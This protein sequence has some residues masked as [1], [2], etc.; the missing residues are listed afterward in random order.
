MWFGQR[1]LVIANPSAG[2]GRAAT[3]LKLLRGMLRQGDRLAL[4]EHPRHAVELAREAARSGAWPV[5][6]AAGGDG[7]AHEVACGVLESENRETVLAVLPIG[8]ANDYA[9]ALK[10]GRDWWKRP[11]GATRV[12]TVDAGLL[13]WTGGDGKAGGTWFIN[14]MGAGFN[15]QVTLESRKIRH[16]RGLPLYALAVWRALGSHRMGGPWHVA[17]DGVALAERPRLT[18]SLALGPREGN[19]VVAPEA[20][21]TDGLFDALAAEPLGVL[22][23]LRLLPGLAVGAALRH[24]RVWQGRGAVVEMRLAEG[25]AFIAHVDGELAVLPGMGVREM[26]ARV[27]PGRL[28]VLAGGGFGGGG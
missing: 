11:G 28:R 9:W 22:E 24:P 19:F 16:L 14:G 26:T 23:I 17:V 7:T 1:V 8:S 20:S 21:L 5:I 12:A 2:R 10:L 27:V 4:T 13:E 15:G 18:V 6:A 3:S 25:E